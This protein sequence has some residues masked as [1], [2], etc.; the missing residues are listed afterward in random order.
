M[1]AEVLVVAW[2]FPMDVISSTKDLIVPLQVTYLSKEFHFRLNNNL[3]R[4]KFGYECFQWFGGERQWMFDLNSQQISLKWTC[5]RPFIGLHL[6]YRIM[7]LWWPF[8]QFHEPI[9]KKIL[10][11]PLQELDTVLECVLGTN[12]TGT[13]RVSWND[14]TK[15]EVISTPNG[16]ITET[17]V[18]RDDGKL[19]CAVGRRR[20]GRREKY[21]RVRGITYR[22][23]SGIRP[24]C[25]K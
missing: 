18:A 4:K 3:N 11:F 24:F 8:I 21:F 1:G 14:K 10:L 20:L 16:F 13:F 2:F 19:V 6:E 12:G 15:N 25:S 17:S 23:C 22:D 9:Y 7:K 5:Q